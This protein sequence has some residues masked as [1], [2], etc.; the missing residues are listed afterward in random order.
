MTPGASGAPPARGHLS[1]SLLLHIA[2][3][4]AV[5]VSAGLLVAAELTRP[6][7][8]GGPLSFGSCETLRPLATQTVGLGSILYVAGL[9]A[10][11][12]WVGGLQRRRVADP[13]AARDWYL[14]SATIGLPIA[15]LLAFTLVSA[16]R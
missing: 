15:L 14:L 8:P 13:R 2:W 4:A 12:A 7:P 1:R 16:L 6:C 11:R 3:S 5:L 9:T 10:V